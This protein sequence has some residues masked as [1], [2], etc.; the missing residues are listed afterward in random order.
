MILGIVCI[1]ATV[2]YVG[3]VAAVLAVIFGIIGLRRVR[4]G[5][6][7]NR[8][9]ALTG[10]ILGIIGVVLS[11]IFIAVVVDRVTGCTQYDRNSTQFQDCVENGH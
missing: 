3:A 2:I 5:V 11:A 6:A 7:T 4:R 10:L 8:G 9:Q 1:P